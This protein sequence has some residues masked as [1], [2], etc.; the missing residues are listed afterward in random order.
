MDG[1]ERESMEDLPLVSPRYGFV[2]SVVA[3]FM[4]VWELGPEGNRIEQEDN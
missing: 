1:L 4:G 2:A 3:L